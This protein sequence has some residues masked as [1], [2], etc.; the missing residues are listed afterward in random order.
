MYIV[1]A[2]AAW[3]VS[4]MATAAAQTQLGDATAAE[5]R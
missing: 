3:G 5:R 1:A 2:M 4:E